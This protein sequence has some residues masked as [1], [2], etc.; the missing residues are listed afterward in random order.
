FAAP[1]VFP[2]H[3]EARHA[4]G[5]SHAEAGKEVVPQQELAR[6][7]ALCA[8]DGLVSEAHVCVA[9]SPPVTLLGLA[10]S[11]SPAPWPC[12]GVYM[13]DYTRESEKVREG[14]RGCE[15]GR[16]GQMLHGVRRL[17]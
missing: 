1:V 3:D 5:E 11:E 10:T 17:V 15:S 2:L 13:A 6:G 4:R 7:G 16:N 9:L 8:P 14:A 12:L